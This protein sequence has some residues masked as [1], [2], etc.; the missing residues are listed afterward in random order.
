LPVPAGIARDPAS[1]GWAVSNL[2]GGKAAVA[3][4]TNY[5]ARDSSKGPLPPG[6][7]NPFGVAVAHNGDLYFVDIHLVPSPGGFGPADNG[8]GVF[9][10]TFDHG[11]PSLP[12]PIATG[13]NFPTSVTICTGRDC[14]TPP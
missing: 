1:G 14:P 2:L 6:P 13:L 10:V 8:G 4:F 5:G 12:Q 11:M 9:K 3:W 7:Y